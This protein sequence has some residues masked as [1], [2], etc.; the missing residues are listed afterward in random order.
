L[1]I[2]MPVL[3]AASFGPACW[4]SLRNDAGGRLVGAVYYPIFWIAFEKGWATRQ[5]FWYMTAG[6][7]ADAR[8]VIESTDGKF[9]LR[10]MRP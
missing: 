5:V 2:G 1:L 10:G 3:Y 7:S 6:A 8:P 9:T 4:I